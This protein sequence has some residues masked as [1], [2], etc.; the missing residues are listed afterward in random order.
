MVNRT[1]NALESYNRR[2]NSIFRKTP[3]LIEFNELVKNESIHQEAIL[4]DIRDGKR[5]E[6]VRP[7]V[8]IPEIPLSYYK[9]KMEQQYAED[10]DLSYA[11]TDPEESSDDDI[12]I[13][14]PRSKIKKVARIVHV[15]SKRAKT[16]S[17]A[18][19][20]KMKL[21]T[22]RPAAEPPTKR[23]AAEPLGDVSNNV[24]GCPKRITKKPKKSLP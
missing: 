24:G 22:K 18:K 14:K 13:A 5:R 12:P 8:W 19:F 21:P 11:A 2:F 10:L 3:L 16:V 17:V 1:N 6:K 20:V 4:N 15:E 7:A 9:F 23:P